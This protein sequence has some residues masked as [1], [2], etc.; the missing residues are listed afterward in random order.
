MVKSTGRLKEMA[1]KTDTQLWNDSCSISELEYSLA[2]DCVGATTNPVIVGNVLK[3]ELPLW[4]DRIQ[5]I[6]SKNPLN[7]EVE[8]AWAII[9]TMVINGARTLNPIFQKNNGKNGRISV[10]TNPQDY[11]NSDKMVEQALKFNELA[12]NIQ[13]KIPATEAGIAAIEEV[14]SKGVNVNAT[15]CFTVPQSI[16]VA[17]AVERGLKRREEAG[18]SIENMTPV[19]TIMIGRLDDWLKLVWKRD[20]MMTDPCDIEWA[21]V[22]VVKRAYQIFKE[23]GY[24]SRL[25][26]GAFRNVMHMEEI[27]GGDLILTATH[28]WQVRF[29]TSRIKI[30]NN[31]DKPVDQCHIVNLQADFKDFNAAFEPD[32]LK[33][34]DFQNFGPT[35]RTLIQFL[36]GYQE[37]LSMVRGFMIPNKD[38]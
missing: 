2:N 3:K 38:L 21:G 13:V 15:V 14:T 24:R 29:D 16:A 36:E 7:N 4:Q 28:E 18:E 1:E 35:R 6:I 31:I 32:G 11:M 12:P 19:C 22:A 17:E 26:I 20:K 37:L 33:V 34:G 27:L 9:E 25:L 8:N 23:K 10:Q 5:E 30:Q